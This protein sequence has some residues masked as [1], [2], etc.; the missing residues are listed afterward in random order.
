MGLGFRG[1]A[2]VEGRDR[3][4]RGTDGRDPH[5][6][7]ERVR[8]R[9]REPGRPGVLS[10]RHPRRHRRGAQG[11]PG[12]RGRDRNAPRARARPAAGAAR[13]DRRAALVGAQGA[14]RGRRRGRRARRPA[15]PRGHGPDRAALRPLLQDLQAADG[16]ALQLA[17]ARGGRARAAL[18]RSTART[19]SSPASATAIE[20][21][22]E[23]MYGEPFLVPE[24]METVFV[25][26]FEGGEV[27]R[28]GHDLAA[29]RRADLLLPPGARDLSDLPR[30]GDPHRAPQRRPLG[31]QPGAALARRGRG[32]E[33]AGRQGAR[34]D[35]PEGRLAAPS[36]ARRAS[37]DRREAAPDARH[38]GDGA[39]PCRAVRA[40]ARLPAGR[41]RSTPTT[42]GRATSR[43]P[44]RSRSPSARSTRRSPGASS[45]RRS[46]R[47][48]TAR[49][50]RRRWR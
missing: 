40:D 36:A 41:R 8:A 23:E 28:S 24:P 17:L 37:G 27:F 47:R 48:P 18:G 50:S 15:G 38:R 35:H 16:H 6:R 3:Q 1:G 30:P 49:T 12:D 46:T 2:R 21:P 5:H 25:S 19:R 22:N 7:L 42:S 39:R 10:R 14:W 13:R 34:E 29:R 32:A 43:P 4:R 31:A 45:T 11:R 20:L 33:R 9:A 26:W 44:S